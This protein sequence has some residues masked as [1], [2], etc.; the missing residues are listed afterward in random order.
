MKNWTVIA[1]FM[2]FLMLLFMCG[3]FFH[4]IRTNERQFN[5]LHFKK[6][7]DYATEASFLSTLEGGNLGISYLDLQNVKIDPTNALDVFRSVIAL[8]YD[9]SLS[10]QTF[11][12]LDNY[13]TTAVLVAAD[14][15]YIA[16]LEDHVEHTAQ[17]D[18]TYKRLKWGLKRPFTI[19]YG[20]YDTVAYNLSNESWVLVR[21]NPS[22][23]SQA[24]VYRGESFNALR[25][26]HGIVATRDAINKAVNERITRDANAVA[27][28]RNKDLNRYTLKDF[29]YLPSQVTSSGVNPVFKPSLIYALSDVDFAG[30]QK[31]NIR[32]VGGFTL[33]KK[34]RVIGFQE[35]GVDYYAF[36]GQLPQHIVDSARFFYNSTEEAALAGFKPHL[37]YL[38]NPINY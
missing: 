36:E 22:N 9:M 8:S 4:E 38:K 18:V 11:T 32:S 29:I 15:Y 35:N 20:N 12:A 28:F 14:G 5:E 6:V 23:P 3:T 21:Q 34:V 17:G 16:T 30:S 10:E 13:I 2:G 31:L 19:K 7:V 33:T 37:E 1:S 26:D 27:Q 24:T 25:I